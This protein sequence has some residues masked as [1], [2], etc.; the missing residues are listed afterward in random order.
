MMAITVVMCW[1]HIYD[2][3]MCCY[4]RGGGEAGF[5]ADIRLVFDNCALY[6]TPDSAVQKMVCDAL[7]SMAAVGF[8]LRCAFVRRQRSYEVNSC[9]IIAALWATMCQT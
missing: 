1:L 8:M 2:A 9:L 3:C 5:V 7:Y 6:S 4:S